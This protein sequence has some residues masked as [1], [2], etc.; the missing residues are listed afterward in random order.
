MSDK[1]K[2]TFSPLSSVRQSVF[3]EAFSLARAHL[4]SAKRDFRPLIL[5][6]LVQG[7]LSP[8][9]I[10]CDGLLVK[11]LQLGFLGATSAASFGGLALPA[12]LG[13]S[14]LL[15]RSFLSGFGVYLREK[16]SILSQKITD[17]GAT[18][19]RTHFFNQLI[20]APAAVQSQS[21]RGLQ[22]SA[23][24][25]ASAAIS[26]MITGLSSLGVEAAFMAIS[27][28]YS[29]SISPLVAGLML[30]MSGVSFWL[31]KRN[32]VR[33]LKLRQRIL[34]HQSAYSGRELDAL[35]NVATIQR[36]NRE[37]EEACYV[38][39][40]GM[41]LIDRRARGRRF[42]F[43]SWRFG[44]L[45][46][47]FEMLLQ[48]SIVGFAAWKAWQMK[49][50]SAFYLLG[51]YIWNAR[52][53]LQR[54]GDVYLGMRRSLDQYH[55]ATDQLAYDASLHVRQ[56]E[57][58]PTTF[59][60]KIEVKDVSFSYPDFKK[61]KSVPVFNHLNLTI[62]KGEHVVLVG[63]SGAGKSSL[64]KLLC[65]AY[66]PNEGAVLFDGKDLRDGSLMSQNNLIALTNQEAQFF[67]QSIAENVRYYKPDASVEEIQ[68]AL[69]K[70]GLGE[71]LADGTL[72]LQTNPKQLS[73]G[74]R[75]RLALAQVFVQKEKELVILDEPTSALD[76]PTA[77]WVMQNL[78][79]TF[80]DKTLIVVSHNPVEIAPF[81]RAM[82]I[83]KGRV[84]E[85]GTPRQLLSKPDGF[86]RT[87]F[88]H[89][90]ALFEGMKE[91]ES[92]KTLLGTLHAAANG[93][94]PRVK[95]T[96]PPRLSL[97]RGGGR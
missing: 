42:I 48:G 40:R 66:D 67:N 56:D 10:Y 63:P 89:E 38:Q 88:R 53:A 13:G 26:Q 6:D 8:T 33:S 36:Q 61:G 43:S 31:N 62:Q 28:V 16:R 65:H 94:R 83:Q 58:T 69:S 59:R 24:N 3:Y 55:A 29:F 2:R 23:Y 54:I 34:R 30:G 39:N 82:V 47:G 51:G 57:K 37:K 80:R 75:Q 14:A 20:K 79:E 81:E 72:T 74:Q 91:G 71:A 27:I 92:P 68:E 4:K 25:Q 35:Q 9:M 41:T 64:S 77:Q 97:K 50:L 78:K 5:M 93:M 76:R 18:N 1:E 11:A 84:C 87:V 45:T 46:R 15:G 22:I 96:V 7:G 21:D 95:R 86:L 49:D 44:R 52:S 12:V 73:G 19:V 85:D 90:L 32:M 70:A 17:I 60:D